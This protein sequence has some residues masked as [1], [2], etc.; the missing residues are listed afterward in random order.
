MVPQQRRSLLIV[1]LLILLA[2]GGVFLYTSF[3]RNPQAVEINPEELRE[4]QAIRLQNERTKSQQ[5]G[6]QAELFPFNPN[7]CDSL[8]FIRLG[9]LPWQAHNALQYRRKGG[10]WRSAEH[11]SHLY[12]LSDSAYRRLAPY[13]QIP[14]AE[15]QSEDAHHQLR[16]T[17][18]HANYTP[19][20]SKGQVVSLNTADTTTLK[21]VPG[22]GSY[23]AR[24][25]V[26]YREQLGGF[27]SK[28]Q[29][30]EIPDLP[31]DIVQWV[32]IDEPV[33]LR[34]LNVNKATFR[35]LVRHPYL[36]YEQVK[37]IFDYRRM[38]GNITSWKDLML[39]GNFTE[40]EINTRLNYYFEF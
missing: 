27:H 25:I 28:E 20:L 2:A 19:K 37:S 16:D 11:F 7:Q 26:T 15:S 39:T 4:L 12:G 36:N 33:V 6:M 30:R 34:K 10:V 22:I 9:L 40:K 17:A 18:S 14:D 31:E 21:S 38:Y 24:K 32:A 13:I 35:Q 29:L 23:Y 5:S 1:T 8:S 3:L